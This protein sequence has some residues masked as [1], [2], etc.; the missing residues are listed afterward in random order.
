MTD[1]TFTVNDSFDFSEADRDTLD[2]SGRK[3]LDYRKQ[4]TSVSA[5]TY[6]SKYNPTFVVELPRKMASSSYEGF[7]G[8]L[9]LKRSK[10]FSTGTVVNRSYSMRGVMKSSPLVDD[11]GTPNRNTHF[12]PELD[13]NKRQQKRYR[14]ILFRKKPISTAKHSLDEKEF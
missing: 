2:W 5:S 1:A 7:G 13:Q 3:P 14:S 9:K 4:S 10:R 8:T 6:S 11:L 12:S